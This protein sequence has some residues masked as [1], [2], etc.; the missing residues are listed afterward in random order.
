[1]MFRCLGD[2]NTFLPYNSFIWVYQD[3]IPSYVEEHLYR[4]NGVCVV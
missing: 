2:L 3:L 1:M 4:E